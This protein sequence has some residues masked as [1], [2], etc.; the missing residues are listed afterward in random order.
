M[1]EEG[2]NILSFQDYKKQMKMPYVIYTDFEAIVRKILGC[3]RERMQASYTEKTER[4]EAC[5][6]S[7]IVVR[8]DGKV[9]LLS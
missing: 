4:H 6:Y 1:P 2:K 3:E 5:G 7:Y 9:V 8:S